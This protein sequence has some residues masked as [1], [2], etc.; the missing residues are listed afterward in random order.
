M[1]P[2]PSDSEIMLQ[3]SEIIAHGKILNS[4]S[5][6][7]LNLL[8]FSEILLHGLQAHKDWQ[9]SYSSG[10]IF[11]VILKTKKMVIFILAS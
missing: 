4:K 7:G 9:G 3:K 10:L 6:I 2:V 1:K 11:I 5:E 8:N